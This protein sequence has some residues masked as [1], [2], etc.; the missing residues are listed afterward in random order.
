MDKKNIKLTI[1]YDGT[2]FCGW[3][4]QPGKRTVQGEIE[5]ALKMLSGQ[6]I[7]ITAS[8]RTDSGVHALGQVANFIIESVLPMQAYKLGLDRLLPP[9]I[10]IHDAAVERIS[11]N[12]RRD[13]KR[14]IY[15]YIISKVTKSVGRQYS[16]KPRFR[17]Q[18]HPMKMAAE[19]LAGEHDFSAFCKTA[20]NTGDCSSVVYRSE[21]L[22]N[23]SELI[24]EIEAIRYFHNMIR[25]IV[26]TLAEVG[27]GKLQ[28][29]D[30]NR[31]I[32]SKNRNLAGPTAPAHGLYLVKVLYP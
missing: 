22:E 31:I 16:W 12:A 20:S 4:V 6:N 27:R 18:T 32:L 8:G 13:A 29:E 17:L 5:H 7:R 23:D 15:R 10:T 14:R 26:G 21:F 2:D 11:F 25:I 24:F 1:E 9:D 30:F 3:Q 19:F 28:P